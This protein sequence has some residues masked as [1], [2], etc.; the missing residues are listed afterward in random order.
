MAFA[1]QEM[2]QKAIKENVKI[3][4][5]SIKVEEMESRPQ[6]IQCYQ[7]LRLGHISTVCDRPKQ[8]SRCGDLE[9][10]ECVK[11]EH[12]SNCQGNHSSRSR[13][14]PAK[15]RKLQQVTLLKQSRQNNIDTLQNKM[16]TASSL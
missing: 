10:G 4:H 3:Q 7:C 5:M 6:V 15:I 9:H 13:D 2:L 16:D 11:K 8:C 14:C 12:C 1:C